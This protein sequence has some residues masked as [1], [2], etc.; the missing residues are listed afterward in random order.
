M[1]PQSFQGAEAKGKIAFAGSANKSALGL[2]CLTAD[3]QFR[4]ARLLGNFNLAGA[5]VV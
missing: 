4:P 5:A 2:I 3:V 1:A